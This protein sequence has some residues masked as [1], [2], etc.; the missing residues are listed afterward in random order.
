MLVSALGRLDAAI[1]DVVD[2][3][4]EACDLLEL[5]GI[6]SPTKHVVEQC[7]IF[8]Q[9]VEFALKAAMA[10][11]PP[12]PIVMAAAFSSSRRTRPRVVNSMWIRPSNCSRYC[13]RS[14]N[15]R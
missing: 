15:C 12:V 5:Y 3:I 13:S 8:V 1:D 11:Q 4:E 10:A 6:E 9:A 2:Y 14:C 7:R